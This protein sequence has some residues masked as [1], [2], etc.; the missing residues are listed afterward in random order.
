MSMLAD[1]GVGERGLFQRRGHRY[2]LLSM[3]LC[4]EINCS[5]MRNAQK[6]DNAMCKKCCHRILEYSS[7]FP[8]VL[9]VT[10]F[11]LCAFSWVKILVFSSSTL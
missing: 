2:S 9:G 8:S 3:R 5:T 10:L 1:G 7:C 6:E 4:K 11:L